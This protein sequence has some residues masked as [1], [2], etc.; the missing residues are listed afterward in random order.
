MTEKR[1]SRIALLAVVM[2]LSGAL[3]GLISEDASADNAVGFISSDSPSG[4]SVTFINQETGASQSVTSSLDGSYSF[5]LNALP[6]GG[7]MNELGYG[8]LQINNG[9]ATIS[10]DSQG[11]VKKKYESFE[12]LIDK[13]GDIVAS[14]SF[15]PCPHCDGM[16]DKSIV[17]KGNIDKLSPILAA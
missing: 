4:V 16:E 11:M 14:F 12:G 10:K 8:T 13:N 1:N 6:P 3:L 15:S 5:T 2:L 9:K 17:F 7:G